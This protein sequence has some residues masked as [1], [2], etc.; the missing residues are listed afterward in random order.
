MEL[1][2]ESAPQDP[3]QQFERWRRHAE[4]EGELQPDAMAMATAGL[5]GR[6]SA[7][8]VMLRGLDEC[9]FIFYTNY[10][11][12]K[13]LELGENP[14]GSIAFY[15]TKCGRQVR[16]E[17]SVEHLTVEESDTYFESRSRESQ[18][19]AWASPQ[20]QL[21][22]DRQ[23]LE[24]RWQEGEV[25]FPEQ[26]PRPKWW[27]GFRLRPD[28]IEFWQQR[29]HRMHDRLRYQK[30]DDGTWSLERLAPWCG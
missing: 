22:T 14:W 19:A 3:L 30:R 23:W 2:E 21:I 29:P 13:A 15:W 10:D 28:V 1:V 18:I 27:G 9:G 8:F 12:K 25:K 5:D 24:R 17:G 26:L 4:E 7:R 6:P 11:S 20:S 16:A